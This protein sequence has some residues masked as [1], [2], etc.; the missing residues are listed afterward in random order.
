M[1][2][3]DEVRR[4]EQQLVKRLRELR[5]LVGEYEQLRKLADRLGL[6]IEERAGGGQATPPAGAKGTSKSGRSSP[7]AASAR[8]PKTPTR[9]RSTA[10]GGRRPR[11]G[12]LN[13]EADVLR[14]VK[15]RPG[16][17][18]REIGETLG[19]DPTNLY[20]P[21]RRLQERGE[22]TKDGAHLQPARSSAAAPTEPEQTVEPSDGEQAA[23]PTGGDETTA[24]EGPPASGQSVT[25]PPSSDR[26]PAAR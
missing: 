5:P 12:G 1:S 9:S 14:L 19:L 24:P 6:H 15:E 20:R 8:G 17:T 7:K 10:A 3:L 26:G 16:V 2:V 11:T 22:I 21:V 23:A 13:R 4:V 18:V 25:T